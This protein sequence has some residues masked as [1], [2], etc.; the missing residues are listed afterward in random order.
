M[1]DP[2]SGQSPL[3]PAAQSAKSME[4]KQTRAENVDWK[5]VLSRYENVEKRSDVARE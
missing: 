1:C 2:P 4:K 5:T 3:Q